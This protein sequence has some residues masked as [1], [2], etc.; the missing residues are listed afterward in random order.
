M[1]N[2]WS[3]LTF[4]RDYDHHGPAGPTAFWKVS[5][6]IDD[7]PSEEDPEDADDEATEFEEEVEV[8]VVEVDMDNP[9]HQQIAE[10]LGVS[11]LEH[12]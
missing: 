6:E 9:L 3:L 10:Q 7:S 2:L 11:A 12:R 1:P 8:E 5:N 4:N